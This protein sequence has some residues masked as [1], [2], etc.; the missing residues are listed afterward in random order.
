MIK[1]TFS[2]GDVSKFR[3]SF[4]DFLLTKAAHRLLSTSPNFSIEFSQEVIALLLPQGKDSLALLATLVRKSYDFQV[5]FVTV[6]IIRTKQTES[7]VS[8]PSG[9]RDFEQL[10]NKYDSIRNYIL[11]CKEFSRKDILHNVPN[12]TQN[13][14]SSVINKLLLEQIISRIKHGQYRV[15]S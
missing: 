4:V 11:G 13:D 6:P 5:D 12:V 8:I 15:N 10:D 1:I 3:D 7:I 9:S 2:N 14:I